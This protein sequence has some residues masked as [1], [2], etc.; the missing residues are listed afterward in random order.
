MDYSKYKLYDSSTG[1]YIPFKIYCIGCQ[2]RVNTYINIEDGTAF[3][4]VEQ[5]SCDNK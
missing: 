1:E 2:H 5:C 3:I 4:D